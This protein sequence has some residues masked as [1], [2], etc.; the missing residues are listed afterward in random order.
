MPWG[1][2]DWKREINLISFHSLDSLDMSPVYSAS[3]TLFMKTSEE[4]TKKER[5]K[6]RRIWRHFW[7]LFDNETDGYFHPLREWKLEYSFLHS[8]GNGKRMESY[9]WSLSDDLGIQ[10]WHDVFSKVLCHH[11]LWHSI[12]WQRLYKGSLLLLLSPQSS[13]EIYSQGDVENNPLGSYRC[14]QFEGVTDCHQPQIS[15]L[16]FLSLLCCNGDSRASERCVGW[17]HCEE[18]WKW[19]SMTMRS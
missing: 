11:P 4:K 16:S 5:R 19:R 12:I 18:W 7:S 3:P 15:S 2:G 14:D 13:D 17:E 9:S 1:Q 10:I 6:E 8:E